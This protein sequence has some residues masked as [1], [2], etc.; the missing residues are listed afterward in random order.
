[1]EITEIKIYPKEG[2]DKK[3]RAFVAITFDHAFVVR[4]IKIIDGSKGLF[5]AMPSRKISKIGHDGL[6]E[7]EHRDIAHPISAECR[8]YLE[9]KI[10]EAY[11][12]EGRA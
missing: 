12:K 6:A 1:M 11:R 8:E 7:I 9:T 2:A 5:V 4:D 3:L 10:I